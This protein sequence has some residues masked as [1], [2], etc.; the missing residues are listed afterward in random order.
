MKYLIASF[1]LLI[2][3]TG[4]SV[5][6]LGLEPSSDQLRNGEGETKSY[7]II[8]TV[9]GEEGYF[10]L[11]G[12]IPFGDLTINHAFEKIAKDNGGDALINVRYWYRNS[13][14]VIGTYNSL[15]VK[16]DVIKFEK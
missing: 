11:F 7:K 10:S 5:I 14:Y 8:G 12:F 4:C 3:F 16:A 1:V 6:P 13:F 15:E 2:L 9:E